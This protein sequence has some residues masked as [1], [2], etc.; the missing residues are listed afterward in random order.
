MRAESELRHSTDF[1]TLFEIIAGFVSCARAVPEGQ[2]EHQGRG[3]SD[4]T[5]DG[6]DVGNRAFANCVNN[7][8]I[9]Y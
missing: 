5:H 9:E 1:K 2:G 4:Y 8:G 7:D 6:D 3:H